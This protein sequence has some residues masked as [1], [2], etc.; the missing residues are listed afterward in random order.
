MFNQNFVASQNLGLPNVIKLND[1]STG[2]DS[3]ITGRRIYLIKSDGTYLV[4]SGSTTNYIVWNLADTE[5]SLNILGT[6]R[7]LNVRVDWIAVS[8]SVLYTKTSLELFQLYTNTFFDY[9]I[10]KQAGMPD[11]V[12]DSNYYFNVVKL[13]CYIQQAQRAVSFS[14]DISAAQNALDKGTYMIAHQNVNF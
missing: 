6:D 13:F 5:I 14:S 3:A 12:N 11:I 4:P 2:S 9:L 7:A 1:T 8:G 10:D